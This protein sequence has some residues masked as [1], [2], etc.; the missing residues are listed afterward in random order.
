VTCSGQNSYLHSGG[1]SFPF[2]SQNDL[3]CGTVNLGFLRQCGPT[4]P[5]PDTSS[6][7]YMNPSTAPQHLIFIH[8]HTTTQQLSYLSLSLFSISFVK[9]ATELISFLS[10]TCQQ[11]SYSLSQ[12]S[13]CQANHQFTPAGTIFSLCNFFTHLSN[14]LTMGRGGYNGPAS[15]S[16]LINA[17]R[18][19]YNKIPTTMGRGGYNKQTINMGR[20][21][22]NRQ[23]PAAMGR[24][25]YN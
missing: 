25:G 3:A 14:A 6:W 2:H 16:S 24:G 5:V 11:I 12:I 21:G 17:G 10:N 18:G 15:S 7:V 22:Y 23:A 4:R 13:Y 19:G 8:Q 1:P 9:P 20:G